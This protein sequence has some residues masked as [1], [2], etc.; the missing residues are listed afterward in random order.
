M[1]GLFS[2]AV[3]R[4]GQGEV[5]NGP[6]GGVR[7]GSV[8]RVQLQ[9]QDGTLE[10]LVECSDASRRDIQR[11]VGSVEVEEAVRQC[12]HEEVISRLQ[13]GWM[14]RQGDS[15]AVSYGAILRCTQRPVG[16]K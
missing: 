13:H 15:L 11:N 12:V 7:A 10:V 4:I 5:L 14:P 2:W 3:V 8:Y 1:L 6:S 9:G 16:G